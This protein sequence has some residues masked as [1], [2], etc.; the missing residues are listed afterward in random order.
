[1]ENSARFQI[2]KEFLLILI[3]GILYTISALMI[4]PIDTIPGSTI[5]IAVICHTVFG[6]NTGLVNIAINIPIMICCTKIFGKKSL[7]YTIIIVT[8]T[9]VLIDLGAPFFPTLAM[10]RWVLIVVAGV[11]MGIGAGLLMRSGGTMAGTTALVRI[12]REHRPKLNFGA[13]LCTMDTI[14]ILIGVVMIRNL[15]VLVYSLLYTI[16]VSFVMD[17]IIGK[18]SYSQDIE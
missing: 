1:M 9:S 16:V 17:V 4:V 11:L 3:G 13:V 12:L 8:Y 18:K 2:F 14:I 5:G 7:I 10:N 15:L 6:T